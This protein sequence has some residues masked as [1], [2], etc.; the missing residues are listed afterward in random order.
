ME[1]EW[2][3][4]PRPSWP[5]KG[6]RT[7][8]EFSIATDIMET[9]SEFAAA[10]PDKQILEIYLQIGELTCIEAGQLKFCYESIV[11]GTNLDNS[12]LQIE[13]RPALVKCP[14]CDYEGPPRRW[15]EGTTFSVPTLQCP[16]CGRATEATAGHECVIKSIRFLQG[17]IEHAL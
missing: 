8:H 16:Q 11:K 7:M 9:V 3:K 1:L 4:S 5:I 13:S 15:E 10:H 14:H 12:T 17:E 6:D 2:T